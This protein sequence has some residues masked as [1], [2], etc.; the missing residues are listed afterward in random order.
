MALVLREADVRAVLTMPATINVLEAAFRAQG[1]G[2]ARNQP[3]R[4][5]VLP[6]ARGVLHMLSAYVPGTPGHPEAA[7]PG[8]VGFKAYT[9]TQDGARFVVMLYSGEDGRLLALIEADWLGQMRTGAASGVATRYMARQDARVVGLIG[10]GSQARTQV[11]AMC[12][13]RPVETVFV[14]GRDE[15]RRQAFADEM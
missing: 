13:A 1:S 2:N 9:T 15:A 7:G 11:L 6:E 3:R 14:Y 8:L 5:I 4:R 12:A 10:T